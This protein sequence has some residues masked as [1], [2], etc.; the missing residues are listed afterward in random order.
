MQ[1]NYRFGLRYVF[2]IQIESVVYASLNSREFQVEI[3]IWK[4]VSG[5]LKLMKWYDHSKKVI[6]KREEV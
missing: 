2:H 3:K 5:Y 4:L 6:I 1:E